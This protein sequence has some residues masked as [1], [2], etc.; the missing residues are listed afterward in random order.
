DRLAGDGRGIEDVYPLSPLQ[1]GLLFHTLYQPGAGAYIAP[2]SC[3]LEGEL[4]VA[5][6]QRA[7]QAVIDR[8]PV[9][10]SSFVWEGLG[11]PHQIV[12]RRVGLPWEELDWRDLTPIEQ[13]TRREELIAAQGRDGFDL[14]RAPLMRLTL[15]H[16]GPRSWTFIWG[17]HHLLVDGWTTSRLLNEVFGFYGA[18]AGGR[19]FEPPPSRPY[20]DYIAWLERQDLAVAESWWRRTLAGFTAPTPLPAPPEAV[21]PEVGEDGAGEE[22]LPL[23]AE[24]ASRLEEVAQR[25]RVTLNTLFQG[26]WALLLAH[27]AGTSDVV[28]GGV[29]A[30]RPYDLPGAES[31]VGPFINTLPVRVRLSP[32]APLAEWL[33]SLQEEQAEQRQLEHSPLVEVQGWSDVPRGLPLFTSILVFENYPGELAAGDGRLRARDIRHSVR[34]SYPLTLRVVP[35]GTLELHALFDRRHVRPETAA[36]ILGRLRLLLRRMAEVSEEPLR[37]VSGVLAEE[38]ARRL[39]EREKAYDQALF[40][41]FKSVRRRAAVETGGES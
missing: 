35:A 21:A 34:N 22:H 6:L 37:T 28:F 18:F 41:R 40:E 9:L 16:T 2:M 13:E 11:R 38:D 23:T 1:H 31:I 29:V 4:D 30:G 14:S 8:H 3:V 25:H 36:A 33:R 12:H 17:R 10:R 26:A 20:G 19:A 7:W 27:H 5:A 24:E 15:I 32:E 39:A